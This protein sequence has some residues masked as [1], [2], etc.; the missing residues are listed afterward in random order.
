MG[1]TIVI[2]A[3]KEMLELEIKPG[4]N[5]KYGQTIAKLGG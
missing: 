5:V 3:P 4:E 1:S 2:L